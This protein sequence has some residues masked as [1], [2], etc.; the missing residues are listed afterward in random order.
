MKSEKLPLEQSF[1]F[2]QK[3]ILLGIALIP[4]L[5]IVAMIKIQL[6]WKGYLLYIFSLLLLTYL[7]SLAFSKKGIIKKEDN[8]YKAKFFQDF[9]LFKSKVDLTDRPVASIL[10][11][12][13]S[14]KLAFFSV[15]QP[16]LSESFNSF[17]IFVLNKTHYKRDAIMYFKKETSAKKALDFITQ[18]FPLRQEIFSPDPNR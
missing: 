17:V 15:A 3:I 12:R 5:F 18:D 14:Q 13:K 2:Q 9:T 16:D 1:N 6:N 7:I 4:L 8:I 10:K 11:F